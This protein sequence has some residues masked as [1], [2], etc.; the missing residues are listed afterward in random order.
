ML[1]I[2]NLVKSY[3]SHPVLMGLSLQV[4]RGEILGLLGVNG[5]GKTT[6]LTTVVGLHQ[7][8]EGEIIIDGIDARRHPKASHGRIGYA[9]QDIGL[10]PS[11]SVRDNM[12]LFGEL[13]GLSGRPLARRIEQVS[14]SLLLT[15]LLP[16]MAGHLSGGQKRRL[17][18]ALALLHHP[19]L[20]FLDEPTVGADVQTRAALLDVVRQLAD[21]GAAVIYTSHYFQEIETLQA[22]I[23]I[24]HDGRIVVDG[25]IPDL[26][27]RFGSAALEL[28]FASSAPAFQLSGATTT[29]LDE[30]RVRIEIADPPHSIP[31]VL[32]ALGGEAEHVQA[33]EIKQADLESIFLA[34]TASSRQSLPAIA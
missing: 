10:Y 15:E 3:G 22:H 12:R 28:T 25:S 7:A 27:S 18:T 6:L 5:S 33:I 19:P 32:A 1:V 31:R 29:M 21:E 26:V 17:H 8:D 20:L 4:E 11:I 24:L 2:R 30:R 9:P 14:E 34:V 13:A 16:R 23:A